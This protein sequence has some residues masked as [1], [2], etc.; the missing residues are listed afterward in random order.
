MFWGRGLV[1]GAIVALAATVLGCGAST[2]ATWRLDPSI[3]GSV[4]YTDNVRGVNS[5]AESDLVFTARPGFQLRG[6]GGRLRLNLSASVSAEHYAE[7]DGLGGYTPQI[8]GAANAELFEDHLFLDASS[9]YRRSTLNR[10]GAISGSG[11]DLGSNQSD[12]F[13]VR[14][15]PSLQ[16]GFGR[17]ARSQTRLTASRSMYD[18]LDENDDPAADST[19]D[20]TT[21]GVS[22]TI[23]SGN[24]FGKFAW[25]LSGSHTRTRRDSG[26]N[27]AASGN[28]FKRSNVQ[29]RVSYAVTR[30]ATP[31]VRF[32]A[33][34]FSDVS[35]TGDNRDGAFF[36]FGADLR[37]GPRTTLSFGVGRRFQ[38]VSYDGSFSY[39]FSSAL[40][41]RGSYSESVTTQQE[42]ESEPFEFVATDPI[43]GILI[44]TRTGLPITPGEE[45]FDQSFTDVVFRSRI[46]R[47]GLSGSRLRNT[48]SLS[49]F[50]SRRDTDG[51]ATPRDT[52]TVGVSGS[53]SRRLWPDLSLSVN[54]S[55]SDTA[56]NAAADSRRYQ[57]STSLNYS[58][59]DTL[60]TGLTVRHLNRTTE[61]P[62]DN[63]LTE[64]SVVVTVRKTF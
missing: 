31:Y 17:W 27:N 18:V 62:G 14:L 6:T 7:T 52:S 42:L 19:S 2:A 1:S 40:N 55:F 13:N 38:S 21:F 36:L 9:S 5:G 58:L 56:D 3:S 32:G 35:L 53:F 50:L 30:W 41:L 49:W 4:E 26:G 33:D 46:F 54:G 11:R 24:R 25:S 39:R 15:S 10:N 28:T 44:D 8:T 57:I 64:N 20:S 59:S 23:S 51:S 48:Y 12:V 22:E 34:G 16:F 47:M 63:E 61:G 43:T 60:N 45:A 29:G 37:P